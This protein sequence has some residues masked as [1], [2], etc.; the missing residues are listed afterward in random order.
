[1]SPPLDLKGRGQQHSL[2]GEGVGGPNSDDWTDRLALWIFCAFDYTNTA[3]MNRYCNTVAFIPNA[4]VSF[5]MRPVNHCHRA[6][7]I[8]YSY[9]TYVRMS[10]MIVF[11][12]LLS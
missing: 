12:R 11:L 1:M 9:G 5:I 10:V 3:V 8:Q 4:V 2:A 6:F 7:N